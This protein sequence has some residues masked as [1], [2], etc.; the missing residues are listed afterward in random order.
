MLELYDNSTEGDILK[1]IFRRLTA[2]K[3]KSAFKH[4]HRC[5]RNRTSTHVPDL[6]SSISPQVQNY[7]FLHPCWQFKQDLSIQ[8]PDL[9]S[10]LSSAPPFLL[11]Y[12]SSANP[13]VSSDL[14][15]NPSS[16]G[17][18]HTE[19]SVVKDLSIRLTT[20][21]IFLLWIG[22]YGPPGPSTLYMASCP[23]WFHDFHQW[24]SSL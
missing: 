15:L 13:M 16:S 6:L 18:L 11:G 3:R 14:N 17:L 5:R 20:Q 12:S 19:S 23:V 10:S 7:S 1:L 9:I 22:W 21:S 24:Q 4:P 8:L 2:E